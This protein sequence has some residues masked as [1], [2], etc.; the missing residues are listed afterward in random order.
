MLAHVNMIFNL[1]HTF[2]QVKWTFF[3]QLANYEYDDDGDVVLCCLTGYPIQRTK[4]L[5]ILSIHKKNNI[6]VGTMQQTK[7]LEL[8]REF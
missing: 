1:K 8:L 4:L 6:V 5:Y 3:Q 2:L 7:N